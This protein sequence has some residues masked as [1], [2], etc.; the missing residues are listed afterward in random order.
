MLLRLCQA[1]GIPP[2]N[3]V[4]WAEQVAFPRELGAKHVVDSSAP[5]FPQRHRLIGIAPGM[6]RL[7]MGLNLAAVLAFPPTIS[8]AANC[9]SAR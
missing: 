2:V 7:L 1:G 8:I 5:D 3:I 9:S 6:A 4:C